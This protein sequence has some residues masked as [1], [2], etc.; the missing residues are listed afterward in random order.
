MTTGVGSMLR[1]VQ[2]VALAAALVAVLT[3]LLAPRVQAEGRNS[4]KVSYLEGKA[5]SQAAGTGPKVALAK[6]GLVYEDDVVETEPG[7]KVE[8]RTQDGSAIRVGPS[9]KLLVK[10]AYFGQGGE[11]KFTAKLFFGQVWTKVTGLVG[12]DSKFEVETDNAVAGVRGTTFRIDAKADKS[13]IM[14]VYAGSVA[15]ASAALAQKKAEAP[16]GKRAQIKGPTAISANEWEKL[17]GKMMQISVN[18]DGTS[19]E[20]TAFAAK[21]DVGDEWAAWNTAMDEKADKKK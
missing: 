8:L 5:T 15:M 1:R 7:A 10:S 17:V 2:G 6:D 18:A 4:A 21:D 3:T 11:K 20:P 9:S 19:G 16:K 12:G 13:V 14:R